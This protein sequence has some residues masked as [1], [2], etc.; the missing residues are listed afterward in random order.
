MQASSR[1]LDDREALG[2][3]SV[4]A[5]EFS[6]AHQGATRRIMGLIDVPVRR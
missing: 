1:L 2:R 4:R 6:L 3:M 5:R